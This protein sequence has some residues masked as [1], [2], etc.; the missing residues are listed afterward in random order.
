MNRILKLIAIV[1]VLTMLT[2]PVLGEMG[3][4]MMGKDKISDDMMRGKAKEMRESGSDLR[5]KE[6]MMGMGFMHREGNNFGRYVTFSVN[7]T[8]GDVINYGI[9][10]L[11]VFDSIKVSRFDLKD[12]KSMGAVTRITNKDG[13][14]VIQLHDNPAAVINIM[15]KAKAEVVFDL[16][17]GINATKEE[18]IVK[19]ESGNFTAYIASGNA[20]SV[21]IAGGKITIDTDKGL[22]I[23]RATPVNMPLEEMDRGFMGEIMKNRAGAEVSV[24]D[25][26]KSSI[27]NYSEDTDVLIRSMEKN[28]MRMMI[29]SSGHSGKFFMMN[30]DNSSLVWN[31]RQKLRLYLDNK[32]MRQVMSEQELYGTNESSFWLTMMGKNRMQ[33]MMYISNFSERQVDLVIEDEVTPT[34]TPEVTI[35][36]AT[37]TPKTP[38]FD[39]AL[40]ILCTI[41]VYRLRKRI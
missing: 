36:T 5:E 38:G 23:F 27:V 37:T 17:E 35:I 16:S 11:T 33:A 10:G 28:R 7:N 18:N 8:T 15:S 26:D 25:F 4:G 31:E 39:V 2:L 13:S 41:A 21:N 24:G 32:P 3:N 40:G 9:L 29:N 19:I 6:G 30:I 1:L 12:I 14:I 20:T 34:A 22:T